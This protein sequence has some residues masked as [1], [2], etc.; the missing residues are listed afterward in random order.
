MSLRTGCNMREVDIVDYI[1]IGYGSAGSIVANRLSANSGWQFVMLEA[2]GDDRHPW[3]IVPG[4]VEMALDTPR[5]D[6][7]YRTE[8][9][10]TGGGTIDH[11]PRGR[12][13]GGSSLVNGM[14]FVRG[15]PCNFDVWES[16]GAKGWTNSCPG[17]DPGH[18]RCGWPK[19]IGSHRL[20][21][22]R[23][24]SIVDA[25]SGHLDSCFAPL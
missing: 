21:S 4:A 9:D 2:G 3:I 23:R 14:A 22:V 19:V 5:F 12:Q 24:P 18:F 25:P 10:P 1:A 20:V 16:A 8:T 11:V 15:E 17:T 13:A 7:G 6:W